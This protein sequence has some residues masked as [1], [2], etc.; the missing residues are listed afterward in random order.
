MKKNILM[1]TGG[2]IRRVIG[3]VDERIFDYTREIR[4]RAGKPLMFYTDRGDVFFDERGKAS[5]ENM[6]FIPSGRDISL[7]AEILGGYSVYAF[8]EE[9]K[10]GFITIEGGHRAGICGRAVVENGNI[11]TI[12]NISSINIRIARQVKGCADEILKYI[13]DSKNIYSTLVISPPGGGKTTVLRDI[14]RSLSSGF[15]GFRGVTV[16]VCDER[17]ELAATYMGMAQNDLGIRTDVMDSCP[18]DKGIYMLLRSMSP[19]VIAA[20]EIGSQG[21]I[22]AINEA[23]VSG[24]KLICTAHGGGIEDIKKKA[25]GGLF[26][27]YVLLGGASNPGKIKAVY[28]GGF[29]EMVCFDN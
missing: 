2:N 4:L 21:D 1:Y 10:N 8:D 14:I 25:C 26:E 5:A 12:R 17:N 3:G 28:D 16:G 7:T 23:M 15:S 20:D 9:I 19:A 29:K 22:D 6:A 11:K 27:R 24:V 18:K 13:I